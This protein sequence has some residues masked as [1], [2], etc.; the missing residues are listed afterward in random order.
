MH[1]MRDTFPEAERGAELS[2]R[3]GGASE[4]RWLVLCCGNPLRGD[5]AA[6]RIGARH[7]AGRLPPD[8]VLREV[9]GDI[10]LVLDAWQGFERVVVLDAISSGAAPGSVHRF[11]ASE[12][13]LPV[14][15]RTCST[16]GLGVA[17]A[18]ELARSLGQLPECVIVYGVEGA[19]FSPGA[20]LSHEIERGV[21][22]AARAL[23]EELGTTTARVP[24]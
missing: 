23:L 18:V 7:L 17:G 9:Q 14:E 6:G 12:T 24:R 5:D 1:L 8:A 16:H 20:S 21:E 3:S 11:D 15:V 22:E 10:D 2:A 4:A 13:P 19:N